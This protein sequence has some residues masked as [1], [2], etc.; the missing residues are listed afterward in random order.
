MHTNNPTQNIVHITGYIG[1][2]PQLRDMG[3]GEYVA[4]I[5]VYTKRSWRRGD[6]IIIQNDRLPL[7]AYGQL[8][9]TASLFTK[10]Q[11]V[12]FTARLK[13][14]RWQDRIS[15]EW[16]SALRVVVTNIAV[17][18]R[19][20]TTAQPEESAEELLD[21]GAAEDLPT[22]PADEREAPEPPPSPRTRRQR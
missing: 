13:N 10:G 18:T 22:E 11:L 4:N 15:G 16:R 17:I 2:T 1:A 6:Q 9:H 5:V 12:Q 19:P 7:T 3:K 8:A 20:G 21:E 14:D